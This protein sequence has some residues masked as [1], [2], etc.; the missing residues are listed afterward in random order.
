MKEIKLTHNKVALVDSR[1]YLYLSQFKWRAM[2]DQTTGRW[3]AGRSEGGRTILMHREIMDAPAGTTVD[4]INGDG[5]DNRGR[6]L[7]HATNAQNAW[8]RGKHK[9][10]TTGYKGVHRDRARRKVRARITVNGKN[11]HL[12]WFTDPREAALAYDLAVRKYHGA[13]GCTNF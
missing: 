1:W 8:N 7:R 12:G 9:N 13:Y 6:N 3:Y 2:Y 4:H 10:N 11:I 5:L